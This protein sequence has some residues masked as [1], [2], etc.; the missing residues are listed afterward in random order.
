VDQASA[1]RRQQ[2][3]RR[4]R[5]GAFGPIWTAT[6][7]LFAVS[8]LVADG[9]LSRS[10]LQAMLP[11]AGILAIAAIGQTLVIQQGGL[12][13]SVPGMFSLGVVLVT[14]VPGGEDG[15]LA[16][17]LAVVVAV[18][19]AGGLLNG[20]L[21]TRLGITSLVA[22]LGMNAVLVGTVLQVTH[23]SIAYKATGNWSSFTSS[24][25]LTV[26]TPTVVALGLVIVAAAYMRW[27]VFGRRF[28]LVGASPVAARSA[29][30][31]VAR[32]QLISY[33]AAGVCYAFAGALLAGFLGSPQLFAGNDYL[34]PTIAAVV[35]GGTALGGGRGSVVATAVGVLF[36]SQ[37]EQ[38]VEL[39]G[40]SQAV[41]YVIQGAIVALGMGL[42]NAPWRRLLGTRAGFAGQGAATTG[43]VAGAGSSGGRDPGEG[44]G[45]RDGPPHGPVHRS[46]EE[47]E[48][49]DVKP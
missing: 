8:P 17:A 45:G 43:S 5:L 41:Q 25:V 31:P 10:A 35:L 39:L 38:V 30:L 36:L 3:F 22:T 44:P 18:G 42:R 9:A 37:L 29:G 33:M 32:Y 34:L 21:V 6:I 14:V 12:D 20:L 19:L 7:L 23:G 49:V 28:D 26:P 16:L 1:Q 24:K 15:K 40:A 11:F 47:E 2:R 48:T 46:S 4:V 27:S 13:L